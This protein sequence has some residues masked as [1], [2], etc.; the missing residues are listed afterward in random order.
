[1]AG[2]AVQRLAGAFDWDAYVAPS[3]LDN[4]LYSALV[5]HRPRDDNGFDVGALLALPEGERRTAIGRTVLE[6]L[7]A[8]LHVEDAEEV[9]FTTEFVALGLDSLM[10]LDF[11]TSLESV[12]RVALPATLTFDHPSPQEVTEFLDSRLT[13][14]PAAP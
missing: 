9:D 6:S 2:S 5:R 12:F 14:A 10:A 13:S 7:A 4:A 3:L 8:A 11:R 1:M